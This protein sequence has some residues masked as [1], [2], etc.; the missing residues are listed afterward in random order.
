[1]G[2]F[3]Q[4][5]P[6]NP[7]LMVCLVVCMVACRGAVG[8]APFLA[9]SWVQ[10]H[11][12]GIGGVR[13]KIVS[14]AAFCVARQKLKAKLWFALAMDVVNEVKAQRSSIALWHGL[15]PVAVDGTRLTLPRAKVL[16]KEFGTASGGKWPQAT[17]TTLCDV[18]LRMP[19]SMTLGRGA[20]SERAGLAGIIGVLSPTDILLGDR[21]FPSTELLRDLIDRRIHFVMRLAVGGSFAQ[22]D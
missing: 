17:M 7:V 18:R 6:L 21:G 3:T 5:G 20:S 11:L 19:L 2:A 12:L 8:Y 9:E 13:K 14:A 16:K 4:E 22:V 10:I 15:R 1:M